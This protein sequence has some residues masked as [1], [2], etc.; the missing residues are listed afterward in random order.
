MAASSSIRSHQAITDIDHNDP[1]L[2]GRTY[3]V[4]FIRV[5][6][7]A[8]ALLQRPR[9]TL[10]H[11]DEDEGLL[12]AECQTRLFRFV[13]DVVVRISLD[14]DAQTRVDM[15]STSRLGYH[16]LGT[17]RRRVRRFFD[18]LDRA[19]ARP[20]APVTATSGTTP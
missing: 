13:D 1:A 19:V 17:N 5:W 16:D 2:R 3:G 4:P 11:Q 12:R 7:G 9:W 18:D 8:L 15:E 6:V 10:T 14:A 20:A